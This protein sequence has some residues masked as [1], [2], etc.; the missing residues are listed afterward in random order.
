MGGSSGGGTSGAVS[1]PAYMQD[2]HGQWLVDITT[3]IGNALS[4]NPY[5]GISAY[6]PAVEVAAMTD[7]LT[8]FNTNVNNFVPITLWEDLVDDIKT[9]LAAVVFDST[10]IATEVSAYSAKVLSRLN[11]SVLPSYQRGMQNVRAVMTSSFT[12]GEALLTADHT[13]DINK[14]EADLMKQFSD[15][16]TESIITISDKLLTMLFQKLDLYRHITHYAGETGRIKLTAY[17]EELNDE[18]VYREKQYTWGLELFQYGS[19]MLAAISGG[20]TQP[21]RGISTTKS[22][23]G[24]ALSGASMGAAATGGNPVGAGIG[25]VVGGLSG[26][27]N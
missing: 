2:M 23:L 4:I 17:K 22:V 7:T 13:R 20:T 24:G 19:N 18:M 9:K 5:I 16:Q 27:L 14:F 21:N 25:A 10:T 15:R 11:T 8:Q 12:I 26:L 3:L 1:Y 6:D